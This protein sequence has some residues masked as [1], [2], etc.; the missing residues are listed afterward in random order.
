MW[1]GNSGGYLGTGLVAEIR[2]RLG[3]TK[4]RMALV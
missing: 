1:M 3:E 2:T 4:I